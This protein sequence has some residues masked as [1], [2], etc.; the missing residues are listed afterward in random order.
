MKETVKS[1]GRHAAE[2]KIC[3]HAQRDEIE[4]DFINLKCEYATHN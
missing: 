2:C 4:R 3:G 1:P